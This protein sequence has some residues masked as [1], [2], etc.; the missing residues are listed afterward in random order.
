MLFVFGISALGN[1]DN[2]STD[3]DNNRD[4]YKLATT[5]SYKSLQLIDF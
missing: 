1:Y 3:G 2:K 4:K 5:V